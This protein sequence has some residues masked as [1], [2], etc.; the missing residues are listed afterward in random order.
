[1]PHF[2]RLLSVMG[3]LGYFPN[4]AIINSAA[5]NMDVQVAIS[6]PGAHSF[7]ICPGIVLLDRMVVLFLVF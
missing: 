7:N 5:I 4:L 6:C 1:M 3:H 2:S